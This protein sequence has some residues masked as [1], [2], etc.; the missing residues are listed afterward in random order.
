MSSG[1][2]VETR[3]LANLRFDEKLWGKISSKMNFFIKGKAN[4]FEFEG[5][6]Y[7][8]LRV[9]VNIGDKKRRINLNYID[10]LS[11]IED[12]PDS[13]LGLDGHPI[14]ELLVEHFKEVSNEYLS[15]MVLQIN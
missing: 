13:I 12:M 3:M 11:I 2:G 6:R 9:E 15:E 14:E 7:N 5:F 4:L 10:N 1:Y 8:D